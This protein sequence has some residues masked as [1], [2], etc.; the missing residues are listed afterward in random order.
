MSLTPSDP[1]SPCPLAPRRLAPHLSHALR[2]IALRVTSQQYF[3]SA[4]LRCERLRSFR[5]RAKR[6]RHPSAPP[7]RRPTYCRAEGSTP[8]PTPAPHRARLAA[9]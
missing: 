3:P 7:D 1:A 6:A 5:R 2:C 8:A 4:P 9:S